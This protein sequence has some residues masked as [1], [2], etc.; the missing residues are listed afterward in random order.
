VRTLGLL[1]GT[2][3]ANACAVA[4]STT[5]PPPAEPI[6]GVVAPQAPP[7][8]PVAP[9]V[10]PTRPASTAVVVSDDIREY[11]E[12]VDEILERGAQGVT[13]H[14]LSG[15][16]ANADRVLEQIGRA[17]PS[18]I[19]AVGLL[20][21]TVARR[22]P[23]TPMVFCQVYN[24]QDH[25]LL[26]ATSK[27]V[28]LLPPFDLQLQA[29]QRLGLAQGLRSIG[30][31]TGPGQEELIAEIRQ[32]V[33]PTGIALT[34]R[35]VEYDRGTLLAFKELA[36]QIDGLWLLPDNR[37]LSPDVVREIMS[38]STRHSKQLVVFA[39]SLLEMGALLS[40]SSAPRDVVDRV[41]ARF[42]DMDDAGRLRGPD[43]LRLTD[44]RVH[45]N[46]AVARELAQTV[47]E[48]VARAR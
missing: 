13:V 40:V 41:F 8:E 4:P 21:A 17:H 45:I 10:T 24:Y 33:A 14:R 27:G 31:I 18:R 39:D 26:S 34:V 30:V 1:L 37:V 28:Q 5:Q 25:G 46:E 35:T 11:Q 44:I 43:L 38:Y 16:I 2:M 15:Q 6:A 22:I 36:P 32:V 20:A 29:W 12:I 42:A 9:P 48:H 23:D 47:P 19:I 7:A 3:L